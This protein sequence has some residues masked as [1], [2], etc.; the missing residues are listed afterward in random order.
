MPHAWRPST[1]TCGRPSSPACRTRRRA[2]AAHR[3]ET[4]RSSSPRVRRVGAVLDQGLVAPDLAAA[5]RSG[6]Y[7]MARAA[8]CARSCPRSVTTQA[9]VTNATTPTRAPPARTQGLRRR[10]LGGGAWHCGH[11]FSSPPYDVQHALHLTGFM[12]RSIHSSAGRWSVADPTVHRP[13]LAGSPHWVKGETPGLRRPSDGCP[14]GRRSR[15]RL[16]RRPHPRPSWRRA[17]EL[18]HPLGFVV[19]THLALPER[20]PVGRRCSP[21]RCAGPQAQAAAGGLDP[22]EGRAVPARAGCAPGGDVF[23]GHGCTVAGWRLRR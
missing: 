5:R 20:A 23:G 7:R 1:A 14:D 11:S 18:G 19:G 15:R 16:A 9:V 22:V 17:D 4:S 8:L 6:R 21:P 2:T 10:R 12:H 13:C 3:P